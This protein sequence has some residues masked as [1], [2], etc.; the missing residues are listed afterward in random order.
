MPG[1]FID[2]ALPAGLAPFNQQLGAHLFV[3]YARTDGS[4]GGVVDKFNLGGSFVARIA[5]NG[6]LNAPWGLAITPV[7]FGALAGDPS[8]AIMATVASMCLTRRAVCSWAS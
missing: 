3:T 2:P 5:T 4:V 1:A 8:S 6:S 7:T